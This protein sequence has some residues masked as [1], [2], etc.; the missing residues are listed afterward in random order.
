[1]RGTSYGLAYGGGHRPRHRA[2]RHPGKRRGHR[3]HRL[4]RLA[5]GLLRRPRRDEG[6]RIHSDPQDGAA[7]RRVRPAGRPGAE[8]LLLEPVHP[9]RRRGRRQRLRRLLAV[10]PP[11]R[12]FSVV[13]CAVVATTL[14]AVAGLTLAAAASLAHD[15]LAKV[16]FKGRLSANRE[17]ADART[18]IVVVGVVAVVLAIVTQ[19]WNRQVLISFT[20]AAAASALLPIV[21]YGTLWRGFTVNGLRWALYGGL[22]SPP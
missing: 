14:A 19:H 6:H 17:L 21:L 7:A 2:A 20:F 10:R 18:A 11:V 8:A 5:H 13:A 15:V 16:V 12:L 4:H 22:L 1:M 3:L 9:L